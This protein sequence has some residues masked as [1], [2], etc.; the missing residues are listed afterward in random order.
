MGTNV[1]NGNIQRDLLLSGE[2]KLNE[3]IPV[4]D[5]IFQQLTKKYNFK[6]EVAFAISESVRKGKGIKKWEDEIKEKCPWWYIEIM[7]NIKYLF[8]KACQTH[9]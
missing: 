5:I 2:R 3:V 9:M 1:Y 6:P 4:R 7:S 8:P